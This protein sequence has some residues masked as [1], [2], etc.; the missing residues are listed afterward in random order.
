MRAPFPLT[1]TDL[2]AAR[3]ALRDAGG[4]LLDLGDGVYMVTQDEGTVTDM[5]GH[6]YVTRCNSLQVW[7][8]ST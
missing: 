2:A 7:D 8:E 4:W 5:R 3:A 1:Y 6:E